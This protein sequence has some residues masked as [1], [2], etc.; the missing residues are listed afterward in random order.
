M[1]KFIIIKYLRPK[2]FSCFTFNAFNHFGPN[3][4]A[5]V[6]DS[7]PYQD[8]RI[9]FTARRIYQ[10]NSRAVEDNLARSR[11]CRVASRGTSIIRGRR[12]VALPI[13]GCVKNRG[14][15][16]SLDIDNLERLGLM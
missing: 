6:K 15:L 8:V 16:G 2:S 12:A 11:G 1:K 9:S 14:S 5:P 10:T 4:R 3:S 7:V 13:D